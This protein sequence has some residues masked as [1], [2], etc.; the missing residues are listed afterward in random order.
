VLLPK[1]PASRR[2]RIR[3]LLRR[4]VVVAAL[5]AA[6]AA[7]V[8]VLRD[9][10]PGERA[11]VDA[12]IASG[13]LG[14][15]LKLAESMSARWP[16]RGESLDA[17]RAVI[18]AEVDRAIRTQTCERARELL[19]ERKRSREWLDADPL[20][21]RI[22]IAEARAI[23]APGDDAAWNAAAK[24]FTALRERHPH[25]LAICSAILDTLG[26]YPGD[27]V[28]GASL[29]L[30]EAPSPPPAAIEVLAKA[31]RR[32]GPYSDS[33]KRIR[34][35]LLR[36]RP[37]AVDEARADL[38][39]G[40]A[41]DPT[42]R[43]AA[44]FLLREAGKLTPTEELRYHARNLVELSDS[45]TAERESLDWLKQAAAAPGW[46]ERK[47]EAR[48]APFAD[49]EGLHH[50]GEH[51][52]AVEDLLLAGFVPEVKDAL[53][54]W[55]TVPEKDPES[56]ENLRYNAWRLMHRA[57]LADGFDDFAFHAET[58]RTFYPAYDRPAFGDA[59]AFFRAQAGTPRAADALAA[60]KAGEQHVKDQAALMDKNMPGIRG[61][62]MRRLLPKLQE[63]EAAVAPR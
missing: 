34:A 6:A 12:A 37:K 61:N 44:Y 22:D 1:D 56:A 31:Q 58:L 40:T 8:I 2:P 7:L 30:A 18:S 27:I 57:K 51:E 15:A 60:L 46:Q 59:L 10:L 41:E 50:E 42:P 52:L 4:L 45:Y 26:P 32:W 38:G 36:L 20:A 35:A 5:G 23:A 9:Q 13:D 25:D 39:A 16:T 33:A 49:V 24:R 43:I 3:R 53:R 19:A 48:L 29:E 21:I 54:G 14:L 11:R 17:E 62:Q 47:A 55:M 28:V 63:A